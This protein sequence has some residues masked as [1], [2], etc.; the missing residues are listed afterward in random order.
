MSDGLSETQ[1]AEDGLN[2]YL[3]KT[4][5]MRY[6]TIPILDDGS[7]PQEPC[8]PMSPVVAESPAQAKKFFLDEF[9]GSRN[10]G[11]EYDDW[12]NLRVSTLAKNVSLP[13][14]VRE[15]DNSLWALVKDWADA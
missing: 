9:A 11:V 8:W 14:G 6:Y 2:A 12:V 7:G 5:Q 10:A 3:V 1:F 4:K 15:D 13:A